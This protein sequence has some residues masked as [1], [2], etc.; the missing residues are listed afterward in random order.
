MIFLAYLSNFHCYLFYSTLLDR[1][2]SEVQN[3][4]LPNS[5]H[6]NS[7]PCYFFMYNPSGARVLSLALVDALPRYTS[8]HCP[9]SSLP[10][11]LALVPQFFCFSP[12]NKALQCNTS[13]WW[14]GQHLPR[15]MWRQQ[16][17]FNL[18]N[19]GCL[20]E[21]LAYGEGC[22]EYRDPFDLLRSTITQKYS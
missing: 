16:C 11:E 2:L 5:A 8:C 14:G 19:S 21:L 13:C 12:V 1:Y 20:S 6:Q 18:T 22:W 9:I 7:C 10:Y 3:I 17:V 4:L 15:A